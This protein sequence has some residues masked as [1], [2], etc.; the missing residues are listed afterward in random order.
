M[1]E[2]LKQ[3]KGAV[4]TGKELED[5]NRMKEQQIREAKIKLA[6]KAEKEMLM[7]RA[8]QQ[9]E[10]EMAEKIVK[11]QGVEKEVESLKEAVQKLKTSVQA[12]S[13]DIQDV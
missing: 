12:R 3:L 9:K 1:K 6:E 7:K 4:V 10:E 11:G 8:L 2:Q 5:A 13:Q